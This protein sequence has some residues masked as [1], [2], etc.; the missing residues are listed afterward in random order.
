MS[1]GAFGRKTLQLSLQLCA[2]QTEN[3]AAGCLQGRFF[4]QPSGTDANKFM[5]LFQMLALE[6]RKLAEQQYF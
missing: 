5:T 1:V 6:N 2:E 4:G 3:R